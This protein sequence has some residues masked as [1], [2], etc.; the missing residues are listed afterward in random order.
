MNI[1][2][3]IKQSRHLAEIIPHDS[4]DMTYEKLAI[5]NN[6]PEKL[7][8]RLC[9]TAFRFYSGIGV[10]AWSLSALLELMPIYLKDE[11][12]EYYLVVEK[13]TYTNGDV[14]YRV[15]YNNCDSL[16]KLYFEESST[17]IEA[18]YKMVVWLTENGFITI[19]ENEQYIQRNG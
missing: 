16:I 11:D 15:C 8:Y 10:P 4:A 5:G 19:K 17:P 7:Q 1:A 14:I 12:E 9:L 18:A 3:N 6:F 13:D 2:T